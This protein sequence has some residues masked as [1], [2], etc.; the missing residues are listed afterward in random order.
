VKETAMSG[1]IIP[2]IGYRDAHRAIAFLR[3][4]LGFEVVMVVEGEGTIV[5]HAQLT[6]GTGMI[7]VSSYRDTEFAQAVDEGREPTGAGS[8]YIVVAD[9]YAHAEHAR[10]HGAEIVMEP[11]EQDYGGAAYVAKD[12]EGN[13]WSFGSYDPWT[14][15]PG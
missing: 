3:D 1:T 2:T 14:P 15:P 10:F 13:T 4:A 8:V 11:E 7:M 6:H 9:P 5:E 12:F